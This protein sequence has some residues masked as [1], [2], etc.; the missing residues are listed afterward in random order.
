MKIN[1]AVEYDTESGLYTVTSSDMVLKHS[2][3]CYL[4]IKPS[5]EEGQIGTISCHVIDELEVNVMKRLK[6]YK[7][8]TFSIYKP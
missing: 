4:R 6:D 7:F 5:E 1:F 8:L 3:S 2:G